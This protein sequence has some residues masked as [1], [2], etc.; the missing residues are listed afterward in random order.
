MDEVSGFC[1]G[2]KRT[3]REIGMW[4]YYTDPQKEQVLK[5]LA[6]RKQEDNG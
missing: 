1:K 4:P 2:C 6:K 3:S 5:E